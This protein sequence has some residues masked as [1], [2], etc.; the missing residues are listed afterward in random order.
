MQFL[1]GDNCKLNYTIHRLEVWTYEILTNLYVLSNFF[2]KL[3]KCH[4]VLNNLIG[5]LSERE[6]HDMLNQTVSTVYTWK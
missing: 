3:E 2:Q 4:T 5:D 1:S 6:V